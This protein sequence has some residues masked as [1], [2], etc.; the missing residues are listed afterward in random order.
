MQYLFVHRDLEEVVVDS[1]G[2]GE[3]LMGEIESRVHVTPNLDILFPS[4]M[5]LSLGDIRLSNHRTIS[6]PHQT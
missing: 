1:K 3:V 5:R 4:A 2:H 6:L